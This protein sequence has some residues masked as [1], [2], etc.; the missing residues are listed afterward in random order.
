MDKKP[1][2]IL[3]VEDEE[4]TRTLY[5]DCLQDAGYQVLLSENG[6]EALA[7]LR[8]E[9]VDL[10]ITDLKMP[11]MNA[12][13]M[14]PLVRKDHP[15][16]PIIVVSAYYRTLQDDFQARGYNIQAFFNKPV[17]IAVLLDK[18]KELVGEAP[19]PP[20]TK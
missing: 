6:L 10:M 17:T 19:K 12:L 13:E 11:D 14:L 2:T 9:K 15:Q 20:K 3:V 8:D 7:E 5:Q 16:L 4:N 18:V 1:M